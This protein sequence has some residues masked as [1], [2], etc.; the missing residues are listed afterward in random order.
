MRIQTW[1]VVDE[2]YLNYKIFKTN[3]AYTSFRPPSV[4]GD[5]NYSFPGK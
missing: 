4:F 1:I 5:E 3:G 2:P